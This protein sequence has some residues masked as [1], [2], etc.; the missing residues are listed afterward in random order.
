MLYKQ[1]LSSG[2]EFL[3]ACE[4]NHIPVAVLELLLTLPFLLLLLPSEVV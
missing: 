4:S 2:T 3:V 1:N